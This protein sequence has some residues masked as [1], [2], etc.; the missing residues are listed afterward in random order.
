MNATWTL[1]EASVRPILVL[2]AIIGFLTVAIGAFATHGLRP[3]LT[4]QEMGWIDMGLRAQGWH[5]LALLAVAIIAAVKPSRLLPA[6]A[7]AFAIGI[8]LFSGGLYGLAL[9]GRG[10][11]AMV[12]PVGGVCLLMGWA[13]LIV[14]AVRLSRRT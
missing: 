7:I 9:I 10:P 1:L 4:D 14:Y 8:V 2:A 6:A 5:A 11:L 13:L 3:V 12:T